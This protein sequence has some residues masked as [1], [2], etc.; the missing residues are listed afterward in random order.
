[1]MPK[2]VV[3]VSYPR[4]GSNLF[5]Q[6]LDDVEPLFPM[7]EIF[8]PDETVSQK[9]MRGL[10]PQGLSWLQAERLPVTMQELR[11]EPTHLIR[12]LSQ[13]ATGKVIAF[14][15]FPQHLDAPAL[16][17][18]LASTAPVFLV[19]NL[20]DSWIS[21]QIARSK[22]IWRDIDT[23]TIKIEFNP[24]EF[25]CRSLA[26]GRFIRFCLE[27][28]SSRNQPWLWYDYTEI[29]DKNAFLPVLTR[30]ISRLLGQSKTLGIR[31]VLNKNIKK[32]D[33]RTDILDKLTNP[34][35]AVE[36]LNAW[37]M[38]ALLNLNQC[39]DF[40]RLQGRLELIASLNK[41]TLHE[42]VDTP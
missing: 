34:D 2:S 6:L 16:K 33:S 41:W 24:A 38:G 8:H 30:D 29:C 27:T 18:L 21:E 22:G 37:E 40:I 25:V 9:S 15:V 10:W 26:V 35:M 12:A 7:F 31:P 23:S 39:T 14:K 42:T 5:L 3:L 1:M 32:Q 36:W 4:S 17:V 28:C 13:Q 19:R 20:L 11:Q